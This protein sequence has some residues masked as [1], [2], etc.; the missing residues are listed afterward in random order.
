MVTSDLPEALRIADR[1][2]V[3]R[4]GTTTAEFGRDATQVDVLAAAAGAGGRGGDMSRPGSVRRPGRGAR[5]GTSPGR[6]RI[7]A[8][9][10]LSGQEIVLLAVIALLWVVPGNDHPVVPHRGV[11]AGR[12]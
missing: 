1:L 10:P 5:P 6:Q 7:I 2:I 8:P 12:C 9:G 11:A 3:V 4:N